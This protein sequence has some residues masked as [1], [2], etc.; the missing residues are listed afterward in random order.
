MLKFATLQQ[1]FQRYRRPGD[2]VFAAAFLA[3]SIFL[4][5]QLGNQ[6]S[7]KNGAK[8][9]AQ[10]SFWPAVSLGAMT[11]FAALHL[12]G[13]ALSPRIDGRWKEIGFW[14]RALEYVLWFMVYVWMVPLIGYLLATILGATLL[15]L[16]AG[17]RTRTML[18]SAAVGG[19]L[20]VVI[21]KSFLQVKIPGGAIYE[22]LPTAARSFMLT[23]F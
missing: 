19:F 6:T 2:I 7:W 16:R 18:L 13:S 9:A 23:Y 3:F 10:P 11:F 22:L 17:Y 5:S 15:A 21:F 14:M 12:L 8:L 4:L 1:M 20:V